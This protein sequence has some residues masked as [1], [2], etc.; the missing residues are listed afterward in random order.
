MAAETESLDAKLLKDL[1]VLGKPP[2]FVG[3]DAEYQDFRFR[4]RIDMSLVSSVSQE[5]MERCEIERS[6]ISLAAVKALGNT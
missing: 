5:L 4:F 2:S 1:R 6:P 3:S